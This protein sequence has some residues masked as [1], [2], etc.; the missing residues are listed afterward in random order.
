MTLEVKTLLND[1]RVQYSI[2]IVIRDLVE[3]WNHFAWTANADIGQSCARMIM[4]ARCTLKP[5]KF[6]RGNE[7]FR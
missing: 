6:Y 2:V 5:H 7:F 3:V 1:F 4:T